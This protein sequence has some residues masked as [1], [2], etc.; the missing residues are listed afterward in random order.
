MTFLH[1]RYRRRL[2]L[3]ASAVVDSVEAGRLMEHVAS[4]PSCRVELEGLKRIT[5]ALERDA[6]Q[7]D[8]NLVTAQ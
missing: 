5:Q 3:L 2:G 4:C 7:L 8:L 6:A 1:F